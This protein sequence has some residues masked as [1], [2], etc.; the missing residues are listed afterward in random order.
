[1]RLRVSTP[2]ET[3]LDA[4]DVSQVQAWLADGGSIGIRPGHAPLL[5]ETV[6]G[7]LHYADADGEH[8]VDLDRGIL[9]VHEGGVDLFASADGPAEGLLD[10]DEKEERFERLARALLQMLRADPGAYSEG[11][12]ARGEE[13]DRTG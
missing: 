6:P 2:E 5:A 10:V 3:W 7:P 13:D 8:R 4:S 12:E 1:M 9:R 11:Q